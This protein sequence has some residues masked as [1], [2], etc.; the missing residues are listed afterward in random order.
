MPESLIVDPAYLEAAGATLLGQV[1]PTAPPPLTANGSDAVSTAINVT[2]PMIEA[3]V[4]EGL[5]ATQ[6][7]INAVGSKI[8]AAGRIYAETDQKLGGQ[9]NQ[10]HFTGGKDKVAPPP[11]SSTN[12][13]PQAPDSGP[14]LSAPSPTQ[15]QLPH[16]TALTA[17]GPG[18]SDPGGAGPATSLNP[19]APEDAFD[20]APWS[21]PADPDA[22]EVLNSMGWNAPADPDASAGAV[23]PA[24]VDG[25]TDSGG[26]LTDQ[27]ASGEPQN[28]TDQEV[29]GGSGTD[30]GPGTDDDPGTAVG[31]GT[32][33]DPAISEVA[34]PG[35]QNG[36]GPGTPDGAKAPAD[37]R[38]SVNPASQKDRPASAPPRG[39]GAAGRGLFSVSP[40]GAGGGG[41]GIPQS[42][43]SSPKPPATPHR[44]AVPHAAPGHQPAASH[45]AAPGP[46]ARPMPVGPVGAHAAPLSPPAPAAP[47]SPTTPHAPLAP[48]APQAPAP[49]SAP[50]AGG[51]TGPAASS[52]APSMPS[53]PASPAISPAA[54]DPPA[55]TGS[56]PASGPAAAA[57]VPRTREALMASIPVSPAR[58]ERDAVAEAASAEAS[59]RDGV[60]PLLLARR[61]A[62]VLNAPGSGGENDF[63]FFWVTA[64]T[65]EGTIV[66]ANSYGITHIPD[67]L[68]LP[69]V[70]VMASADDEIPAG[71][72]AFWATY[73]VMAVRGWASHHGLT[74]RAVIAT[75]E[76]LAESDPGVEKVVLQ[77]DDIPDSAE[78]VGRT[79]LEVVDPQGAE[80]LAAIPD[81]DLL[82]RLP[83]APVDDDAEA[84]GPFMLWMEVMEPMLSTAT[85]R[86][87]AHLR[88]FHTYAAFAERA[89]LKKARLLTDPDSRRSAVADWLYWKR[90]GILHENAFTDP[91]Y[92]RR[93]A[94][95]YDEA[96]AGY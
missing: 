10:A 8:A 57:S 50:D 25:S 4:V 86:E 17:G 67:G 37:P 90:L 91:T 33:N 85:G 92:V 76:Q 78:M 1:L 18:A 58:A 77:R 42:L 36:Q 70:V 61:I 93:V 21:A 54:A 44:P 14:K 87:V 81:R 35:S 20:P 89:A 72:R 96:A 26:A 7:A 3:P 82:D 27:D 83:Q 2:M 69:E 48:A 94:A 29:T 11:S 71:E 15:D 45:A 38:T 84:V 59:R 19:Q 73:P 22:D 56:K 28:P 68:Q 66:V 41:G 62:A 55:D 64:V 49:P 34:G 51:G 13:A 46:A 16:S 95:F 9:L 79:R 31:P 53:P 80:W 5:P 74:L 12:S 23:K 65:T 75:E 39:A 43:A 6:A 63:G 24:S 32:A 52:P 30:D 47:L 60:D 88:A 40:A